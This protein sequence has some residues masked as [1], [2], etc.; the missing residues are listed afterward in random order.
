MEVITKQIETNRVERR[1]TNQFMLD[2]DF[3]VPDSKNDVEKIVMSDGHVRIDEVKPVEN[4]LRVQG[5][6]EFQVLYVAEGFEPTFSCLEGK[7][8]FV[9]MVYT[10]DGGDK[11]LDIK[12][13]R[14]ELNTNMVHSRKLRIKAMV[15]LELE[16][17]KQNV[18]EIPTDVEADGKIF[19]RQEKMDLLKLHTSK[20]DTYRI[21]EELVLPGTKE[22]IGVMLWNDIVNRKLDTKLAVD[23][24][25]L[26]GELLAFCFYES[27]DGKIDWIEQTVPYQGRVECYGVDETM[28]HHVQANLE[29]VHADIRVDEDGEMRIVGIEGTLQVCI[30]VYEEEQVDILED[31]YSLESN[32]VL[33]TKDVEYEQLVLQNNSKCKVMER[34]TI[35][36]LKNEILQICHSSGAIHVDRTVVR[37]DGVLVEGALYISFLFVRA[38]DNMPF[39][40]WQGVVPFSHLMECQEAEDNLTFHISAVLEQLSITL[41]GGDEIE[42]KAALAFH[43]FFKRSGTRK[44]IHEVKVLP[45]SMEEIEKRPSIVGY[46]VKPEDDLWSLAKRYSTS[47]DAIKELN[48]VSGEKLKA[49]DRLLIFKENMSIL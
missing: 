18:E 34:L 9:E 26:S 11:N 27:P 39:D 1:L 35:P 20:K 40:T 48:D 6:V 28:Y 32:C 15:E 21:K 5:K 30:A 16:S 25:Q 22:T 17:Q 41:Q 46:I 14:V 31:M 3:N 24:L 2:E 47:V 49:G 7:I 37:E 38:N 43:G 19:K 33:E 44:M 36:E 29:E 23:E 4:Y 42:V 12:S 45:L 13:V 10:E 8:P